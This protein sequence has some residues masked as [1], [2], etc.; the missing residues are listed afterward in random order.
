MENED[1]L[2]AEQVDILHGDIFHNNL[3]RVP[4]A[5][6]IKNVINLHELHAPMLVSDTLNPVHHCSRVLI[7]P[8]FKKGNIDHIDEF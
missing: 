8:W 7:T 3:Y 4:I 1:A 6:E 2:F 5:S